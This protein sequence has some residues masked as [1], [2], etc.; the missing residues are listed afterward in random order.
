MVIS[1]C[2]VENGE[3]GDGVSLDDEEN[4]LGKALH[5]NTVSWGLGPQAET[6]Q[7]PPECHVNGIAYRPGELQAQARFPFVIPCSRLCD[8]P[9]CLVEDDQPPPHARS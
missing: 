6:G 1:A 5:Q 2:I 9:L 7:R 8:V 3:D 4:P